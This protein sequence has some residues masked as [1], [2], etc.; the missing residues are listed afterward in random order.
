MPVYTAIKKDEILFQEGDTPDCMY[1]VRTGQLGISIREN[2]DE[3]EIALA[4]P[5]ILIGEMSLFDRKPHSTTVRAKTDS[6]VVKLPYDQLDVQL[7]QLPE[8]VKITMRAMAENLRA[9]NKKF[10]D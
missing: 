9:A 7:E 6:S 5:G 4:G 1:I 10:F 2:E 8:W 3:K